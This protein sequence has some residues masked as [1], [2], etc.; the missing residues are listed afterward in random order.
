MITQNK[1]KSAKKNISVFN[2]FNKFAKYYDEIYSDKDY[3]SESNFIL[4]CFKQYGILMNSNIL[5]LGCGTGGHSTILAKKNFKI[6][7]I[8]LSPTVLDIVRKKFNSLQLSGDFIQTDITDFNLNK[9]FDACISMFST[10]CYVTDSIKFK[11]MLKNVNNHLKPNGLFIFDFWNGDAVLEIEPSTK[12][13]FI[14]YNQHRI[15]RIATPSM[16]YENQICTIE[17][18]CIVIEKNSIIDEFKELHKIRYH[19]TSTLKNLLEK[20]GFE[21]LNIISKEDNF[22]S[23]NLNKSIKNWYLFV[24]ARKK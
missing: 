2:I 4:S 21:I 15:I 13:K 19:F 8:D 7:G 18:H 1:N 5:D 14:E 3:E 11:K 9:K 6:T 23:E 24:I 10:I 12:V 22:E 17:Y 20:S 16:D